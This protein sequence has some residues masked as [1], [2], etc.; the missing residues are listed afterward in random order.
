MTTERSSPSIMRYSNTSSKASTSSPFGV[1]WVIVIFFTSALF[2]SSVLVVLVFRIN[3]AV[4]SSSKTNDTPGYFI[5]SPSYV[6]PKLFITPDLRSISSGDKTTA[7]LYRRINEEPPPRL[8]VELAPLPI[9]VPSEWGGCLGDVGS[10]CRR[11][12]IA[13][14]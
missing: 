12:R 14:V 9:A 1:R 11:F 6:G 13:I 4:P 2:A 10:P 5:T 7:C 8:F 3:A